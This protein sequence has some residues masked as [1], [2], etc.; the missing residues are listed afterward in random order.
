MCYPL[1]NVSTR[2]LVNLGHSFPLAATIPTQWIWKLIKLAESVEL[3]KI[4]KEHE[5]IFTLSIFS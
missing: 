5:V 4:V 1:S 2:D 3:E